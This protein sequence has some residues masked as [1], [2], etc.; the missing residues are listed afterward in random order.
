M[1]FLCNSNLILNDNL[2]I[3]LGINILWPTQLTVIFHP[4]NPNEVAYLSQNDSLMYLSVT[5]KMLKMLV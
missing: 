3:K 5:S 1:P 4:A 2:I